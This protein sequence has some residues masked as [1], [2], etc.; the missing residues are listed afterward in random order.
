M[1]RSVKHPLIAGASVTSVGTLASRVLGMVRDMATAALF[2][3]ASGGV[4]DAFVI[5]FRFPN[6][7]R[8]LFAEGALTASY[9]PVFSA[10]LESDR[11]RAWQL[12]SVV[13]TW[14]SIFLIVVLLIVEGLL[15][16]V[17]L[18][19]SDVE[20]IGLLLGLTAVMMPYMLFI[21]VA[22]MVAATLHALSHFTAPAIAPTLLNICWLVGVW[23]VA[24]A[25][26]PDK[27]AQAYVIAVSVLIA[28]VLQL[29]MQVPILR[30]YGFRYDYNWS[31]SR[32]AVVE[33][34]QTMGPMLLG[35]AVTQVNT[36]LDSLVAWGLAGSPDSPDR[37]AWLGNSVVYPMKQGAAAAIY[38]G[39]RL[40]QFPLGVIGLAIATAIFPLLSRHA[41]RGDHQKL[42]VDLTLGLRL[43]IFLGIPAS[44]G[45]ILLADPLA[46]LL[47]QHGHFSAHDAARTARMIACYASGVWAYCALPVIVRGY[48]SLGD[49]MTPVKIGVV[50]VVSNLALNLILIWPLA[51]VGLAVASAV[52]A[53]AQTILL[54]LIFSSRKT[55]L[56]WREL[57]A[58]TARALFATTLMGIAC[59][60]LLQFIVIDPG[61]VNEIVRV[62]VPLGVG[63]IV[64]FAAFW[65]CGGREMGMLFGRVGM[66]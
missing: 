47:F 55:G 40:Y 6:L 32:R 54:T 20:G 23:F 61:L 43:V 52:V 27:Q 45:L 62:F 12:T 36:L 1:N 58:T 8:R 25:F 51:E 63:A 49:R 21:C 15:W 44:L 5:A 29:L 66:D 30:A 14:L 26:S 38:F 50:A 60:T 4:M 11:R 59:Y 9:L 31:A 64:Y 42:G 28:G 24:P 10:E 41:A 35:L 2:G 7:F 13:L 39:E 17:W 46:R 19:W 33:I 18:T 65:G 22:A 56:N 53:G 34:V 48:Y 57:I 16:F 37:I 3:L